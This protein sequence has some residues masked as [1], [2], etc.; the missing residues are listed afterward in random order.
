MAKRRSRISARSTRA[1]KNAGL[2]RTV[3]LTFDI[4]NLRKKGFNELAEW[5]DQ[6][7]DDQPA[8]L[9]SESIRF[10]CSG[11]ALAAKRRNRIK[12]SFMNC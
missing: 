8:S 6:E 9:R 1:G 4:P 12:H 11:L 10:Y 7:Q 3:R 5:D 2:F